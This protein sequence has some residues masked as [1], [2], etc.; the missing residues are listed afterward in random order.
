MSIFNDDYSYQTHKDGDG[1]PFDDD[2][3]M[4]IN[5][6]KAPITA[7]DLYEDYSNPVT[8]RRNRTRAPEM[9]KYI[10]DTMTYQNRALDDGD[11]FKKLAQNMG[12]SYDV[13]R[14]YNAADPAERERIKGEV[15][16]ALDWEAKA[17]GAQRATQRKAAEKYSAYRLA[18]NAP[19]LGLDY[20]DMG[21]LTP[22]EASS[23][24]NGTPE[25]R[26]A[27]AALISEDMRLWRP[28]IQANSLAQA[29]PS[30]GRP[31]KEET[32]LER[33]KENFDDTDIPTDASK[34]PKIPA[35]RHWVV[36]TK[37]WEQWHE[38]IRT[39]GL[40]AGQ[41]EAYMQIFAAEGGIQHDGSTTAG[42]MQKKW[43]K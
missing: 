8:R 1:D 38:T 22:Y 34:A 11:D 16:T 4:Q 28:K 17:T 5:N 13:A 7:D 21:G 33:S 15:N 27:I 40:G 18:G 42:I 32:N 30:A 29:A 35:Y 26:K 23:F 12:M 39:K 43:T 6:H 25:D 24:F 9:F 2:Y 41:T 37:D 3:L 36:Q 10:D 20:T 14:K 19:R 31:S